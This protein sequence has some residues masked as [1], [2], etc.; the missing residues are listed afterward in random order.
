MDLKNKILNNIKIDSNNCWIW[1]LSCYS[2]TGYGQLHIRPNKILVHRL[3]YEL[4]N[5]SIKE[6][7]CVLHKCDVRSCCNPEHLFLGT[8]GDNIRDCVKK[9]RHRV[10]VGSQRS[11]SKLSEK[12]I[13]Y[14]RQQYSQGFTHKQIAAKVGVCYQH[15]SAILRGRKWRHI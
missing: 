14:I 10:L 2:G 9:K 12:D 6:G 11:D 1:Q 7:L 4:F 5:G 13:Y 15:I 8:K 3:S